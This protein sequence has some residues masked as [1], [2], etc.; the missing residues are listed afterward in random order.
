[1]KRPQK[2]KYDLMCLARDYRWAILSHHIRSMHAIWDSKITRNLSTYEDF[3]RE[4]RSPY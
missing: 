4:Q 2:V 3:L 1:M